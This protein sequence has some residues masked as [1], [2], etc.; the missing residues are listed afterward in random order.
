MKN[1]LKK[2]ALA[3]DFQWPH[4]WEK[5]D[6]CEALTMSYDIQSNRKNAKPC[7][8]RNH[9]QYRRKNKVVETDFVNSKNF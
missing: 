1:N 2:R 5:Y 9:Q 4:P 7:S 8:F 3:L 6:I